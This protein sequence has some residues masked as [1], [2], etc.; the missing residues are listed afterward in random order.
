MNDI[1]L[2]MLLVNGMFGLGVW[3]G[4]GLRTQWYED[5]ERKIHVAKNE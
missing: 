4:W 2:G 1:F 3:L 5:C